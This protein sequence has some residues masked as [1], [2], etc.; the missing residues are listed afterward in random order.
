ML[1]YVRGHEVYCIPFLR[2]FFQI[3]NAGQPQMSSI[4]SLAK[5]AHAHG[6]GQS[7]MHFVGADIDYSILKGPG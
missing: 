2:A 1:L 7:L 4:C 6:L 5:T 3:T